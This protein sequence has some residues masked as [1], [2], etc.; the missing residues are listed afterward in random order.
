MSIAKASV[1]IA[2]ILVMIVLVVLLC[3]GLGLSCYYRDISYMIYSIVIDSGLICLGVLTLSFLVQP[4]CIILP[5]YGWLVA[6]VTTLAGIFAGL[7][8]HSWTPL[9]YGLG[10]ALVSLAVGTVANL[11]RDGL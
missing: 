8:D 11:I 3:V 7:F 1:N 2:G 5:G 9:I 10:F 6:G 4:M